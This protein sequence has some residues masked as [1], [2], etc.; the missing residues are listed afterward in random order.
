MCGTTLC[1]SCF[2][3]DVWD[4]FVLLHVVVDVWDYFVLLHVVGEV[5]DYFVLL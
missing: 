3:S 5:W 4:N 1:V 2:V